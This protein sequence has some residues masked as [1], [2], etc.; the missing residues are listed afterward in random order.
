MYAILS[1]NVPCLCS[2]FIAP[3]VVKAAGFL[4]RKVRE[5]K[6]VMSPGEISRAFFGLQG[7][8]SEF[9]E[10]L[11]L[12]SVCSLFLPANHFSYNYT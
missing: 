3:E 1:L 7:L 4:A 5:C 10:V 2:F 6:G 12:L 11:E 8:T 9:P